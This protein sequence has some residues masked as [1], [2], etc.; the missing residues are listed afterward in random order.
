VDL[1]Y[2]LFEFTQY[3]VYVYPALFLACAIAAVIKLRGT[4]ARLL[5]GVGFGL[6]FLN[7]L[8]FLYMRLTMG[9]YYAPE[10]I[11]HRIGMALMVF[12]LVGW[13]MIFLGLLLVRKSAPPPPAPA[14]GA[15]PLPAVSA[16]PRQRPGWGLVGTWIVLSALSLVTSA[17]TIA[18]VIDAG[19]R[20]SDRE[21]V[22]IS[23]A[24]ALGL[25]LLI[26]TVIIWLVWLYKAWD[27]VPEEFRSTTPGQAV[28]FLFIP[29]FSL[30]WVFRAVP[31]LSA[32]IRRANEAIYGQDS[33]GA[34]FGV[35]IATC[36][37]AII[38]YVGILAWPLFV[39]WLII[40]NGE[41]NRMLRGLADTWPDQSE[42]VALNA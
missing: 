19:N 1:D 34:G 40:A 28:G 22:A 5:C 39:I 23:I 29:F 33:G 41:K 42:T 37:V 21:A 32:S 14:P 30:Y 8:H 25:L 24:V 9:H 7:S 20:I 35:G 2:L 26:P 38:P 3:V 12:A 4:A 18:L 36:I 17:V 27:A 6:I 31:G 16:A 10:L 13:C 15:P 11:V